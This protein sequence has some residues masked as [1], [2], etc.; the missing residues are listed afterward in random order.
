MS[1]E[2]L[3]LLVQLGTLAVFSA[4]ALAALVQIR[5]L[6]ASNELDAFLHLNNALRQPA[7]REAFRYVQTHLAEKLEDPAYRADLA[8]VGF[9]DARAHPEM[10]ACNWFDEVGTLVKYGLI[11]ERTFLDL[12]ARLAI[13]YWARLEPAI[14]VV[15]RERGPGQYE[16]FEYLAVLAERWRAKHPH[17]DYPSA[18]PRK[19]LVDPWRHRV[20]GDEC[21]AR[22]RLCAG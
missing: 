6:R 4:T 16:N 14:V 2:L 11:D 8:H 12:F 10:D 15:R 22:A 18:V 5:H 9:I 17:G 3:N 13:Y 20:G 21:R 19:T 1:Y 7:L